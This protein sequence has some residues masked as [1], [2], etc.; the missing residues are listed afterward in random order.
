MKKIV[1]NLRK[2][3]IIKY[4]IYELDKPFP[5]YLL[6][7][8][9]LDIDAPFDNYFKCV[10]IELWRTCCYNIVFYDTKVRFAGYKI[11]PF[12]EE[13]NAIEYFNELLLD[14]SQKQGAL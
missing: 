13:T 6:D 3:G 9:K 5:F 4:I 11:I 2:R 1:E 7:L 12:S 8:D 10:T 14:I